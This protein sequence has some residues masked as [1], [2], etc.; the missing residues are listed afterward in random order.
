[1]SSKELTRDEKLAKWVKFLKKGKYK[2][3]LGYLIEIDGRSK[4][5]CCLGVACKIFNAP[6]YLKNGFIPNEDPNNVIFF[7]DGKG[8]TSIMLP[9][10]LAKELNIMIDGSFKEPISGA[11]GEKVCSLTKLND[12]TDLTLPEIGRILEKN[13]NNLKPYK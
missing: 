13:L 4:K 2:K 12:E 1:M 11:Y 7:K 8:S 9:R 10:A 5:Y 3:G 6:K